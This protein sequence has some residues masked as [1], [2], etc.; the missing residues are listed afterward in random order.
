MAWLT[1][2]ITAFLSAFGI[3]LNGTTAQAGI[4]GSTVDGVQSLIVADSTTGAITVV[5]GI[6][7]GLV[8]LFVVV[9]LITGVFHKVKGRM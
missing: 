3:A 6:L 5:A 8:G 1:N 4:I 9:K 2:L 7:I